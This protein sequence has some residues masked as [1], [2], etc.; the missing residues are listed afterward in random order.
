[1]KKKK[2]GRPTKIARLFGS[3]FQSKDNKSYVEPE[4]LNKISGISLDQENI[5]SNESSVKKNA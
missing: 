2:T 5:S 3:L 1:M 4:N